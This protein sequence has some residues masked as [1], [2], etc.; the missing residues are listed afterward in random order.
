[1]FKGTGIKYT[2]SNHQII[3]SRTAAVQSGKNTGSVQSVTQD[4]KIS[5]TGTILDEKGE[6]LLE[7]I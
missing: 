3:L 1:M 5:V 2:I 6:P 7:L 4:G